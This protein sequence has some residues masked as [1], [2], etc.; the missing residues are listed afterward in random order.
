[1]KKK[2]DVYNCTVC[3]CVFSTKCYYKRVKMLKN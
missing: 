3:V 1:M 2:I